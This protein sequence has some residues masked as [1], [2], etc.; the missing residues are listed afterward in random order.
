MAYLA[1]IASDLVPQP[2]S[3]GKYDTA[4]SLN[5]TRILAGRCVPQHGKWLSKSRFRVCGRQTAPYSPELEPD[6]ALTEPQPRHRT[7]PSWMSFFTWRSIRLHWVAELIA[8]ST[9]FF[10]RFS[11][12]IARNPPLGHARKLGPAYGI[13]WPLFGFFCYSIK[14]INHPP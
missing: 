11:R 14:A 8:F 3:E 2:A 6:I 1:W 13:N 10:Y 9:R 12:R 7:P 5:L 4:E